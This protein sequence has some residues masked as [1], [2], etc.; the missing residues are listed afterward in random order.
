MDTLQRRGESSSSQETVVPHPSEASAPQVL[1]ETYTAHISSPTATTTTP[2]DSPPSSPWLVNRKRAA[3]ATATTP[4]SGSDSETQARSIMSSGSTKHR[5][6]SGKKQSSPKS[7]TARTDDWTD[8]TEPVVRRRIQN[9]NAQR[10]FREKTKEQK[11]KSERDALN[12]EHAGGSYHIHDSTDLTAD[13]EVS[14]LPW[15]GISMRHVVARGHESE[16]RRSGSAPDDHHYHHQRHSHDGSGGDETSGYQQYY[17]SPTMA[18]GDD[19]TATQ[20]YGG[21]FDSSGG[22]IAGDGGGGDDFFD[23]SAYYYYP[24]VNEDGAGDDPFFHA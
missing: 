5:D 4:E 17:S 10:K 20:G 7:K 19:A 6:S 8:V 22:A 12:Q 11:E 3:A 21:S 14:G 13:E 9:R 15:G 18:Y 16:S 24:D 2:V 1:A 23:D